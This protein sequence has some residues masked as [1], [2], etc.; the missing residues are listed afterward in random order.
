VDAPEL[1]PINLLDNIQV[2]GQGIR[3]L[4]RFADTL[5]YSSTP[6]GN[7]LTIGFAA[8]SALARD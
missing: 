2:G 3:L 6:T 7:R 8:S 4:R 5:A 1:P